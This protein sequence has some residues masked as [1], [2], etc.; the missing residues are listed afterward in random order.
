MGVLDFVHKTLN[1]GRCHGA[2]VA[3]GDTWGQ[4]HDLWSSAL[5]LAPIFLCLTPFSKFQAD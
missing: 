4:I 3:G 2:G 5:S 1:S